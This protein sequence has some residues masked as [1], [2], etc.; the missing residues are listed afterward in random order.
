MVNLIWYIAGDVR[1][2][3]FVRGQYRD[4]IL[5]MVVFRRLYARLEPTMDTVEEEY[6]SQTKGGVKDEAGLK[7]DSEQNFYNQSKCTLSRLKFQLTGNKEILLANFIEHINGFRANVHEVL[8]SFY[9]YKK[10]KKLIDRDR[11]L[12]IIERVTD[13]DLNMTD[14]QR[15]P[16]G[17]IIHA[18]T[19]IGMGQIFL[20]RRYPK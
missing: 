11:V 12:V 2:D 8:N 5:P 3:V 1:R 7:E 18:L 4:D 14:T 15:D 10:A 9:F 16:D 19:N 20:F 13:P 6:D 17:L